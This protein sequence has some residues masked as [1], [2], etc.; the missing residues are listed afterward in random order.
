MNRPHSSGLEL[1]RVVRRGDKRWSWEFIEGRRVRCQ[2]PPEGFGTR[3]AAEKDLREL[4]GDVPI[5]DILPGL[6]GGR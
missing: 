5:Q 1:Y 6:F 3:A 2:G 4:L